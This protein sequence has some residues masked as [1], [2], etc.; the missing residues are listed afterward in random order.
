MKVE[1]ISNGNIR[2][3]LSE[4]E[5]S[6]TDGDGLRWSLRQVLSVAQG[7]LARMGS[8]LVAELIPVE[9][10]AVLLLSAR[11]KQWHSGPIIYYIDT[12][13]GLFRLAEQFARVSADVAQPHS[14]LFATDDGYALIVYP[15]PHLTRRQA[16]LLSEH[17]PRMGHGVTVAAHVAEHGTLI[18]AG[19]A[20]K[21][22]CVTAREPDPPEPSGRES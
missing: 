5:L 9:G 2:I 7:R 18:A 19:N 1:P 22:L 20:L 6:A 21:K 8:R 12:L 4:Q 10:G 17:A 14:S 11:Q 16:R 3:W 15:T 13:D